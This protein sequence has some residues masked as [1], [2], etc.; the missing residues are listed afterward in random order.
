M[1]SVFISYDVFTLICQYLSVPELFKIQRVSKEWQSR[2]SKDKTIWK[3]IVINQYLQ[4]DPGIIELKWKSWLRQKYSKAMLIT[5]QLNQT[6][7]YGSQSDLRK[8]TYYLENWQSIDRMYS[9]G[10]IIANGMF[11]HEPLAEKP[12]TFLYKSRLLIKPKRLFKLFSFVDGKFIKVH[13][14]FG[15]YIHQIKNVQIDNIMFNFPNDNLSFLERFG[16]K[17]NSLHERTVT[18]MIDIL[19]S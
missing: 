11:L 1:D 10:F 15:K 12:F 4:L 16:V 2:L 19:F 17:I 18:Q 9:F 6:L 5:K 7:L 13:I 3:N 8:E 14:T